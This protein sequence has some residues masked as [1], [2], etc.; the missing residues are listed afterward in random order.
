MS[1]G[2]GKI[3]KPFFQHPP[4]HILFEKMLLVDEIHFISR[5]ISTGNDH[6]TTFYA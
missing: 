5:R 1:R 6:V 3:V 4:F 2:V